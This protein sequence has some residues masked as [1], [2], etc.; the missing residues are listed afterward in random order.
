VLREAARARGL[1]E[2]V[3]RL[4]A[5]NAQIAA[6]A[7]ELEEIR[8]RERQLMGLLGVE[9]E[10][11][12]TGTAWGVGR[13]EDDAW[14]TAAIARA[15]SDARVPSVWPVRGEISRGFFSSGARIHAGVDIAGPLG[16]PVHACAEGSVAFAGVDSVF[17]DMLILDHGNGFSSLYG[18]NQRLAARPG[19]SVMRGDVIAYVGST[20]VSSAPH[21]H[22]EV[23][24][25][26]RA[27]D[28]LDF[29]GASVSPKSA[30]R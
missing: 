27:V 1:A 20:G 13:V 15:G 17:G 16:E 2:E 3:R 26:G 18:H 14:I 11:D 29:F 28:P 22:F 25:E 12:G 8:K 7:D 5:D 9:P 10:S 24:H 30:A 6:L 4:R 23:R 19:Q 21:L